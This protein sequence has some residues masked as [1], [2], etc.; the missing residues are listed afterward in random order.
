M[1]DL[2]L[3]SFDVNQFKGTCVLESDS[4]ELLKSANVRNFVLQQ[5]QAKGLSRAGLSNEPC[6][7]PV[8]SSG[9]PINPL[10][11]PKEASVAKYRGEYKVAGGI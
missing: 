3:I 7:Y 1:Q 5:A 11:G 9:E 10:G 4:D 8:T 2:K 6:I